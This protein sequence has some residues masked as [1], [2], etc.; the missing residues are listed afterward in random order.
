MERKENFGE[1]KRRNIPFLR[2][3]QNFY[4]LPIVLHNIVIAVKL[5]F[6]LFKA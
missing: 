5:N 2:T 3:K 1:I 4:A 6:I